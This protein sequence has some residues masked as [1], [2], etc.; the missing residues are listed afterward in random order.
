MITSPRA[1]DG[2]SPLLVPTD[3]SAGAEK[4]FLYGLSLAHQVEADLHLLH[5]VIRPEVGAALPGFPDVETYCCYQEDVARQHLRRLADVARSKGVRVLPFVR[6]SPSAGAVIIEHAQQHHIGLTLMGT[7]SHQGGTS[8]PLGRTVE[9]LVQGAPG[10]VLTVAPAVEVLPGMIKYVLA[11]VDFSDTAHQ[12]LALGLEIARHE[13]ARLLLLYV[14]ELSNR[15]FYYEM[16]AEEVAVKQVLSAGEAHRALRDL[17]GTPSDLGGAVSTLVLEGD[18][19]EAIVKTARGQAACLIVQG[20][21]GQTDIDY[22]TL[23]QVAERVIRTAPCPV[24]T[25]KKYV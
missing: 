8:A 4:A 1:L 19:A 11:P 20:A 9:K 24:I 22:L 25:V 3:F 12:A 18:P 2:T 17:I 6:C 16:H 7:Y 10:P 13:R 15:H 14:R 23:G 21:H 5:V